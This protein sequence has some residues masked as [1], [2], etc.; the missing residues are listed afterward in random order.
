VRSQ[1]CI[2]D[3]VVDKNL[4]DPEFV[5]AQ[6]NCVLYDAKCDNFGR[7]LK[8]ADQC[9]QKCLEYGPYITKSP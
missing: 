3:V 5:R 9:E 6:L 4:N 2:E 7:R 1:I 8:G